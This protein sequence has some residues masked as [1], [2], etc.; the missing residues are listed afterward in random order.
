MQNRSSK[1]LLLLAITFSTTCH[2]QLV[3]NEGSNKN[4]LTGIDE[5]GE[6][7]DW[8]E[9]YNG[10][11][12]TIDLGDYFLSD[13]ATEPGLWQ[14]PDMS[15]APNAFMQVFCSE[16]NRYQTLPFAEAAYE[17]DFIPASGWNTH[18]FTSPF[19]WDGVSNLIF[20]ICS[21]NNTGYTENSIFLQTATPYASTVATF[22][23][24][25]DA[26]CTGLLGSLYYQRPNMQINGVTIDAGTIQN[27]NVDYPAPYGNWYWSA[28]HQ[29]LVRAEELLAV[30][31]TAGPITSLG[32]EVAS[33]NTI[34]YT[35]IDISVLPTNVSEL[36]AQF[37]PAGGYSNHTNFKIDSEGET[38]YLYDNAGTLISSLDVASPMADIS[39]GRTVDAGT[40][41]SWMSPTPAAS[42]TSAIVYSDT[43]QSPT[44]S[45]NSGVYTG[46]FSLAI[47]NPNPEIIE[48]IIAYT[49]DGSEPTL[50]SPHYTGTPILIDETSV[51]R[52]RIFP[53]TAPNYIPS[54]ETFGTYL[55]D[56]TH[57]TPII[58][59]TTNNENLYGPEGIFDN[60]T[61]DWIKPAHVS[62]LTQEE[63]HPQLFETRSAIRMDGGAGG[64][65]SNPQRSFRLSF[66]HSALGE[67]TIEHQLI[68]DIPFRNRYS[69]IYL[70]NGSNQWLV[71]PYK[72][73]CQVS[74]MSNGTQNYYSAM[75]P[76]T[77]YINGEYFGLY[78]LREKFNTEYFD[79]RE[80]VDADS[81]E[82]LSLSY[83]YNLIL[84]ALEGDVN[85]FF[86]DYNAFNALNP[87]DTNYMTLADQ[88][89]DLTHYTDYVIGE[90]WMGNT[91]WPWNNIKIYRSNTTNNRWRFAL[92]D[93]ELS[94]LPNGWTNCNYN[95][96]RYMLDQSPDYPYIN[97]WLQSIQNETY[98]NYFINRF[99][100]LMN[101]SY[102]TDTLLAAEQAMYDKMAPEMPNEYARWGDPFNIEGQMDEFTDRH[103]TFRDQLACR[104][105]NV[106]EDIIEEF[107]L[108]KEVEI[109]LDVYPASSG[110]IQINTIEPPYYPWTG[111]YFDG[112]PIQITAVAD[113][114]Y[115]FQY[116]MPN[117]LII[118]TL[119]PEQTISV[120]VD[121][122]DFT[123]VF[124]RTQPVDGETISFTVYP[125]PSKDVITISHDNMTLAQGAMF[126]IYDVQGQQVLQHALDETEVQTTIDVRTL[127]S[128]LYY[129]KIH[130]AGSIL[131][132][133]SFIKI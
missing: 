112:V 29:I 100:D 81:V 51:I 30:G 52:A 83:Y 59:V 95:H 87:A 126:T 2:A 11:G 113:S 7:E 114:G 99:A 15:L 115:V 56:V 125:S 32:F 82:I 102:L 132:T 77:V 89:F 64:S 34:T 20:N 16:K 18:V 31:L 54:F 36:S 67:K 88:Y 13:K 73:A 71:L 118:D 40:E 49:M 44:F 9:L 84:R 55:F 8:V 21:Y 57:T 68:P 14:L 60:F 22:N 17:T 61:S 86:N 116:W 37:L 106:R 63:G 98:K 119:S 108:V 111:I 117:P 109:Q 124:E 122:T 94:M 48:V 133:L 97:I 58:M 46:S 66:D 47:E 121:L 72:D 19:I 62:Y 70:R 38:I 93:L 91:D 65:R 24:G 75:E 26:S 53:A 27:S 105:D 43:L 129:I 1:W 101:S 80:D 69:E 104:S 127:S 90:S 23:D 6:Q 3:I 107:D 120:D 25:S 33:T 103:E 12:A 41:I 4:Y 42:N 92:I 78:E 131:A 39:I 128:A 74:L 85:N 10:G 5:D 96:I 76:V 50:L 79:V 45:A 35:Y 123:A 28:R 110:H 130:Q